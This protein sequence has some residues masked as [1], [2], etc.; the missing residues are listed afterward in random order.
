MC[1]YV[2]EKGDNML[3]TLCYPYCLFLS[4]SY[5]STKYKKQEEKGKIGIH[6][7]ADTLTTLN[8][9]TDQTLTIKI[10]AGRVRTLLR[11]GIPVST[12]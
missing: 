10:I 12:T 1:I 9:A 8:E 5:V 3:S 7:A 4:T 2:G 11:L 6:L